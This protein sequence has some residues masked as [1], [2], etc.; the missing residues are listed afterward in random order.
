MRPRRLGSA[1]PLLVFHPS[2]LTLGP[3]PPFHCSFKTAWVSYEEHDPLTSLWGEPDIIAVDLEDAAKLIMA[4]E[5]EDAKV[6]F[7]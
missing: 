3:P 6:T 4:K 5:A 7:M 2:V 1:I